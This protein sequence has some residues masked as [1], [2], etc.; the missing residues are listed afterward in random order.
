MSSNSTARILVVDDDPT[1][2][3]L[4]DV[5]LR[6]AGYQV[7]LANTAEEGLERALAQPPDLAIFDVMLPG[8]D[9]YALCRKLRQNPATSLMPILIVTAQAET[10]DKLAGFNAGADDYLTKPFDPAELAYRIKALLARSQMPN[11]LARTQTQRGKLWSVFG[12]K[13]GVG[14]TTLAVNL[15]VALTRQPNL[16]VALVDTDLEFGDIGAHLNL[17]PSRT[18]MD[19]VLRLDDIDQELLDRVLIRHESGV[20]VL[21]GPY[22][23]ED[24]ERVSPEAL[25]TVLERLT[26]NVDYVIADCPSNYGERTLTLLENSDAIIMVLTPEIGPVKNTST[27]LELA[28]KLD[29]SPLNIHLIL[30]RANSEVGI[31]APEIER[32]LQK[33]IPW[34]LMS[35]GRPVVI[36]VN[37]G[38]PIVM[39]QPQHPFSQQVTRVAE[40]LRAGNSQRAARVRPSRIPA[41]FAME[42]R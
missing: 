23:P 19:L 35:G 18:I 21:L 39:A 37:K 20:K 31:A 32:A 38:A 41:G 17:A 24:A 34:R 9:G 6:Q 26:E 36:S 22:R 25:K 15:A 5:V 13:G 8:M 40:A 33:P 1:I 10:R 12:A 42:L 29:I 4:L 11:M 28:E 14:K 27:F 16:R 3:K 7:T 2:A 30:N